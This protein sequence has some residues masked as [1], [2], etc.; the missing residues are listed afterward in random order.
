[1]AFRET[2]LA[3][4]FVKRDRDDERERNR[5]LAGRNCAHGGLEGGG[6]AAGNSALGIH[7]ILGIS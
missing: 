7:S 2:A 1:M 4:G 5:D 6:T 3:V